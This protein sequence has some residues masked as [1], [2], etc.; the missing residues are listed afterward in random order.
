LVHR[1]QDAFDDDEFFEAA[2]RALKGEKDFRHAARGKSTQQCVL[3]ELSRKVFLGDRRSAPES[4]PRSSIP[5]LRHLCG[6][7][8]SRDCGVHD[9][10]TVR[11]H[12]RILTVRSPLDRVLAGGRFSRV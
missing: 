3:A 5:L 10:M 1:R 7:L 4:A 9:A 6:S 2:C 11:K 12:R 8:D